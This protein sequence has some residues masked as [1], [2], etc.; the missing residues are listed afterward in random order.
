M[1]GMARNTE[2]RREKGKCTKGIKKM[3]IG[4][5]DKDEK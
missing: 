5:K 4:V 2:E 3:K 1:K